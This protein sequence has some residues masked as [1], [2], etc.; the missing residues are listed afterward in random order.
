MTCIS[1]RRINS[2]TSMFP[3]SLRQSVLAFILNEA[4]GALSRAN[5]F[6]QSRYAHVPVI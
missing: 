3:P 6:L 4:L 2:N 5:E 1:F